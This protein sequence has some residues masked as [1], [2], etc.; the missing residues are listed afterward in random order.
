MKNV[1]FYPVLVLVIAVS[2]TSAVVS[3]TTVKLGFEPAKVDV[4]YKKPNA[5]TRPI[6]SKGIHWS[7]NNTDSTFGK[8][9]TGWSTTKLDRNYNVWHTKVG[10]ISGRMA[11]LNEIDREERRKLGI[12]E[13]WNRTSN[14]TAVGILFIVRF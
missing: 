8:S 2:M 3:A 13:E 6:M 4:V 5:V 11:M 12:L 10:F 9:L 14:D 7:I 1:L